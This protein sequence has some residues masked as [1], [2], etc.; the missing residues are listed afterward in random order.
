FA[1]LFACTASGVA[2][3]AARLT[4]RAWLVF[5]AGVV[6]AFNPLIMV[7]LPNFLIALLI[8]LM[9]WTAALAIDAARG[10]RARPRLFA[11]IL[12]G[13]PFLALIPPLLAVF[14]CWLGLLPLIAV[15]ISGTGKRGLKR[16]SR[17]LAIAAAWAIPLALWW[18]VPYLYA[19]RT[20]AV[21]GTI[22]ANTDV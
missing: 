7:N 15:V 9:G 8:A 6:G 12:L 5:V 11:L 1:V 18:I 22:G 3:I 2:A 19:I 13:A 10:R 20:A 16:A 21:S 4:S 17:F 14:L